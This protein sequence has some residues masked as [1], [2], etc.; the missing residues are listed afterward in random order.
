MRLRTW[1]VEV[2]IGRYGIFIR[3]YGRRGMPDTL[4]SNLNLIDHSQKTCA[5][6]GK[7]RRFVLLGRIKRPAWYE[8]S[9]LQKISKPESFP[10]L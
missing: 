3:E 9:S 1:E 4:L 7:R 6:N 10:H 5:S 2:C 8:P